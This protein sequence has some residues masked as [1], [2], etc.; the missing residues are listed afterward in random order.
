MAFANFYCTA[1]LY[2]AMKFH[3]DNLFSVNSV[4]L[5]V[6]KQ[7]TF[8]MAQHHEVSTIDPLNLALTAK[9]V[10]ARIWWWFVTV[11]ATLTLIGSISLMVMSYNK[12]ATA[13]TTKVR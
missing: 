10:T 11:M 5:Q 7:Q 8:A 9:S 6:S 12:R 3:T 2:V 4:A 13:V 1:P